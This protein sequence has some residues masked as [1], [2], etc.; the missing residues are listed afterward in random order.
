ML[1]SCYYF[2]FSL[3]I[4]GSECTNGDVRLVNGAT[5]AQGR[6]EY[7]YEGFWYPLCQMSSYTALMI[8]KH[9]GYNGTGKYCFI[10]CQCKTIL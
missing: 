1:N 7:C 2:S 3:L 4:I 5:P 6:A 9:M 10:Q 8:C